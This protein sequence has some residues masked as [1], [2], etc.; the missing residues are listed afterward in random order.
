MN[1]H[2]ENLNPFFQQ[3]KNL[4]TESHVQLSL[5]IG[6]VKS[7]VDSS[8]AHPPDIPP[9]FFM[10]LSSDI[11]TFI[12]PSYVVRTLNVIAKTMNFSCPNTLV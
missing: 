8:L 5:T 7:A 12:L 1:A 2:K 3:T 9:Y 6:G 11:L 10:I 4:P